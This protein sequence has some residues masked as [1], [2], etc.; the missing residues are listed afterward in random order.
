[1]GTKAGNIK[2]CELMK[3]KKENNCLCIWEWLIVAAFLVWFVFVI[4]TYKP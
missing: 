3:N 1:M 2:N 4:Y